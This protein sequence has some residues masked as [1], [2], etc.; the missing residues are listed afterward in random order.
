MNNNI[1]RHMEEHTINWE[2]TVCLEMK[3]ESNRE[4]KL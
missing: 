4:K 2:E 3:E 1:A